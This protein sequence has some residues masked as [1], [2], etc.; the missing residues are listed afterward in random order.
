MAKVKS[1]YSTEVWLKSRAARIVGRF[2]QRASEAQKLELCQ[3]LAVRA[4]ACGL[5]LP[6][7][8]GRKR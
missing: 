5:R 1:S 4:E 3:L 8:S 7:A 2:W 6:E